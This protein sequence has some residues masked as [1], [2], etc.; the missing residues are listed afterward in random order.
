MFAGLFQRM[1]GLDAASVQRIFSGVHP[2][3]LGLV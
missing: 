3:E 2:A 1:Y